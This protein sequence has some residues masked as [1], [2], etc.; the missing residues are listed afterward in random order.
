MDKSILD[1][2]RDASR[3]KQTRLNAETWGRPEPDEYGKKGHYVEWCEERGLIPYPGKVE[4]LEQFLIWVYEQGYS[5][6]SLKHAKWAVDT[7]HKRMDLE[8]PGADP[9]IEIILAGIIRTKVHNGEGTINQK[10][11]L[12]IDHI[13][14]MKFEDT[15]T[16]NRDK[17]LLSIGFAGGF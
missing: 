6:A 8:P 7:Y 5:I 4:Y 16:G 14:K 3:T 1:E 9:R 17:A 2:L 13:R 10:D 11:A 12:T 15:K